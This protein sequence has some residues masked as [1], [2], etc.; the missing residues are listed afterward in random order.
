MLFGKLDKLPCGK[1]IPKFAGACWIS[2]FFLG[3]PGDGAGEGPAFDEPEKVKH[4][5]WFLCRGHAWGLT[6]MVDL[7]WCCKVTGDH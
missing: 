5:V 1:S 2:D 7:A 3:D 6:V 4:A